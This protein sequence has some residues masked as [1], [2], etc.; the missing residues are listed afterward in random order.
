MSAQHAPGKLTVR[1]EGEANR[2][3]LMLDGNWLLSLLHNGEPLVDR[4]RE[5]MRRLMACWNAGI[6]L[7]TEQLEQIDGFMPAKL[8][9]QV[10]QRDRDVLL[11]ALR[12][13][14]RAAPSHIGHIATTAIAKAN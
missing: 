1:E 12:E 4:Q 11:S 3:A 9:Y 5:N 13:I 14:E 7:S 8:A 6:G 2:Y 10:M